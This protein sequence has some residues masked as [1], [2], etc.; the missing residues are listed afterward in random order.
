MSLVIGKSN[1]PKAPYRIT[2]NKDSKGGYRFFKKIY[3]M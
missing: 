3:G 1:I 2:F